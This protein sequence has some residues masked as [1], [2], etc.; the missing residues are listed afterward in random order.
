MKNYE[1]SVKLK[2]SEE[3]SGLKKSKVCKKVEKM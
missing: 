3:P 1:I 2:E